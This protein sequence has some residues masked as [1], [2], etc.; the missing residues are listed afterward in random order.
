MD[1]LSETHNSGQ[2]YVIEFVDIQPNDIIQH[3][4]KNVLG[5]TVTSPRIVVHAV[6]DNMLTG[7]VEG[8]EVRYELYAA[9]GATYLRAPVLDA[10]PEPRSD[11]DVIRRIVEGFGHEKSNFVEEHFKG[12]KNSP[13]LRPTHGVALTADY[14]DLALTTRRQ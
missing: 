7:T 4:A 5:E 14:T 12:A 13:S 6:Q 9:D 11:I 3:V 1:F 10:N 2:N 8:S